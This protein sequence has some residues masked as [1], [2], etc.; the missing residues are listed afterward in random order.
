MTVEFSAMERAYALIWGYRFD[1]A[2][3]A[4]AAMA[5]TLFDWQGKTFRLVSG[6]LLAGIVILQ[7]SDILYFANSGRHI[8][9]EIRDLMNDAGSLFFTAWG[10]QKAFTLMTLLMFPIMLLGFYKIPGRWLHTI[11]ADR[12]WLFKKGLL[13]FLSAFLI[14]GLFAP[15]P[16]TPWQAIEIGNEKLATIAMNGAYGALYSLLN[17]KGQLQPR[18]VGE[19][20]EGSIASAFAEIYD[21][22][23]VLQ[24]APQATNV[25]FLF[26]E[27][28]NANNMQPY[29]YARQ[30]TPFFD[31][32]LQKSLRPK[33][34]IAGGIRTTEGM[35]SILAS[36][37]NPLGASVAKTQLQDHPYKTIVHLLTE[38]HYSSAFFQGTSKETSGTGA[39]AQK[40][41]FKQSYGKA[42]VVERQYENNDWGVYDQDL[43]RFV[44]STLDDMKPPFVIGVNGATTH[45]DKLP[46]GIQPQN[47]AKD[48]ALNRRLNALHFSDAALKGF[49]AAVE[50]RFPD[51]LFVLLA[52]HSNRVVVSRFERFLI[53][54]AIYGKG[55]QARYVDTY[56]SQRD[57]APTVVDILLG[58]YQ[59]W[60]PNA[61][62]KSLLSSQHLAADYYHN[63]VLGWVEGRAAIEYIAPTERLDCYDVSSF[64]P[65]PVVCQALHERLKAR[66]IAFTSVSQTLL[67]A[68]NT[69]A[70]R[71]Y[72]VTDH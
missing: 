37:Q 27:S 25:V 58:D 67:F 71:R 46:E 60:L 26:L 34:G 3:S 23:A 12:F 33:A 10:Q 39:F 53:P 45:D 13:I 21:D 1:I 15:I 18:S 61:T 65:Q 54:F 2:V 69:Q 16:L 19:Q 55:V 42:D 57:V 68:G 49:M 7:L 64:K 70:F 66:A 32:I 11:R 24:R 51:T 43:Y 17:R 31:S 14:R 8:G 5:A 22:Q 50:K 35:F 30:T 38:H 29:G 47:F 48:D 28:W 44:L 52:D 6:L 20:D 72:R 62:G 59:K 56:A 41:G 40:L 9:Y 36:Y 63:G 4:M